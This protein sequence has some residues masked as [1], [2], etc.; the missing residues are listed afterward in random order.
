MGAA[1]GN[2]QPVSNS[3]N[4]SRT[5]VLSLTLL[6][7][8]IERRLGNLSK[9][10]MSE[11]EG[12]TLL[13]NWWVLSSTLLSWRDVFT[14]VADRQNVKLRIAFFFGIRKLDKKRTAT[15]T[16]CL[17]TIQSDEKDET[18]TPPSVG[19]PSDSSGSESFRPN[20]FRP[21]PLQTCSGQHCFRPDLGPGL[22]ISL[23]RTSLSGTAQN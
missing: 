11:S 3:L 20:R 23:S 9:R 21:I 7:R 10:T 15:K 13:K 12:D 1:N 8:P 6:R 14:E 22:Q 5:E 17:L 4:H 2:F 19:S 18:T 16:L